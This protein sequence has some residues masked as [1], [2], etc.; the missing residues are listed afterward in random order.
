MLQELNEYE[1]EKVKRRNPKIIVDNEQ[2][3]RYL[4]III[5]E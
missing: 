1:N 3:K 2:E 4:E 5:M